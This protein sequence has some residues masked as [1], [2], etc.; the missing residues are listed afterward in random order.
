MATL[1]DIQGLTISFPNATPVKDLS[2]QVADD[3]ERLRRA[4]LDAAAAE[5]G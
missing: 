5:D 4:R 2:F 3:G 1:L